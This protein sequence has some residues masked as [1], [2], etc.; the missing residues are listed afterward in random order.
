MI[1][2]G[3]LTPAN[4]ADA[5]ALARPFAVDVASGVEAE[6]GVKDHVRMAEFLE[7]AQRASTDPRV[8]A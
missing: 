7:R 5:V 3:G 8:I 6:P 1:L 2:A 4:V